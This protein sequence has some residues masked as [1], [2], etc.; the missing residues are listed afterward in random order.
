MSHEERA[1]EL[2]AEADRLEEQ[3]SEVGGHIAEV[4]S[5]WEAKKGDGGVPGA[6][7][8]GQEPDGG[9]ADADGSEVGAADVEGEDAES[10]A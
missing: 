8:A 4:K 5:D 7:P 10:S 6:V 2:E 9:G 1:T 3:S